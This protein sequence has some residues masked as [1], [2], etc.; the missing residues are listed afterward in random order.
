M[1][2]SVAGCLAL[3]LMLTSCLKDRGTFT[4]DQF[5]GNA[6]N[7]SVQ[8][9]LG[10][11]INYSDAA[12]ILPSGSHA[13]MEL[14]FV[15]YLASSTVNGK[16]V[17]VKIA[18]DDKARVD[19][20]AAN[21]EIDYLPLPAANFGLSAT[22]YTIHAGTRYD[23]VVVRVKDPAS[24]D[25]TKS[26]M[27]PITITDASGLLIPENF[28]TIYYHIIGNPIAGSYSWDFSRW[29]NG[30]GTGPLNAASF[31]GEEQAFIPLSPTRISVESGYLGIRY[32]LSF[33]DNNGVLSD[34]VVRQ[35]QQD[36]ADQNITI[37]DG[38]H[39][40]KADPVTGEYIFQFKA[41]NGTAD[42]YLIDRFYK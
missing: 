20:L 16:D 40:V 26:Y 1:K 42:R 19:Y 5:A 33:T 39:I 4:K 22:N 10:G 41:N 28:R 30:T 34:F 37:T 38:P 17:P 7:G 14:E 2:Y 6:A 8:I 25:P 15:L 29:N 21:P 23:T 36:V 35:N 24:L 13:D 18:L 11:M 27:F 3:T 12:V 32:E 9:L 31:T